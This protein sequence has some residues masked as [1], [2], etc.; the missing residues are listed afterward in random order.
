MGH[1][2][3]SLVVPEFVIAVIELRLLCIT[4]TKVRIKAV[5]VSLLEYKSIHLRD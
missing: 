2:W 3:A 1:C 5:V 4:S